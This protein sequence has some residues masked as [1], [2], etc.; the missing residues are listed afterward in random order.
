ML[1]YE[2]RI[3]ALTVHEESVVVRVTG[4]PLPGRSW[5]A[6]RE[7]TVRFG[8]EAVELFD[9]EAVRVLGDGL[10]YARTRQY[11]LHATV[12][13]VTAA[14]SSTAQVAVDVVV[15]RPPVDGGDIAL[16]LEVEAEL[17]PIVVRGD[18][19]QRPPSRN[20]ALALASTLLDLG[21]YKVV[22][23]GAVTTLLAA[24]TGG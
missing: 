11:P 12:V 9:G 14:T 23:D 19:E 15:E 16:T 17:G 22:D 13:R 4:I 20:A 10:L 7:A 2:L 1:R 21:A 5:R 3:D 8:A 18:P 6:L 24:D